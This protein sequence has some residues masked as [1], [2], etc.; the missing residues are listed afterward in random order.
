MAAPVSAPRGSIGTVEFIALLSMIMALA[1]LS[2]DLMLPAF[3]EM[4]SS[5][6]LA[7]DSSRVA[8]V[9]TAFLLGLAVG[10]MEPSEAVRTHAIEADGDRDALSAFPSLFQVPEPPG[11][12]TAAPPPNKK[13]N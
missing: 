9:V 3:G 2:I 5:F 6:G 13:G 12:G 4:R 7:E 11:E 8:G 10:M 1:A